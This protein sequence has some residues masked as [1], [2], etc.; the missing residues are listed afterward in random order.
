MSEEE[1]KVG[2]IPKTAI[3]QHEWIFW[4]VSP[5]GKLGAESFKKE[6][7]YGNG[8]IK[9]G[10]H[11]IHFRLHM[12]RTTNPKEAA[13]IRKSQSFLNSQIRE[14]TEEQSRSYGRAKV[15]VREAALSN[16]DGASGDIPIETKESI[17]DAGIE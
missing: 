2:E 10:S 3:K 7:R 11:V 16:F 9:R 14:V 15:A 6:E 13:Y 5:S 17:M 4:H 8:L 1:K 12:Y